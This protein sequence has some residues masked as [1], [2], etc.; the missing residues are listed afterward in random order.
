MS[1]RDEI[2]TLISRLTGQANVLTIPV[3]FIDFAGSLDAAL[4]LSQILYW[5]D[6]T[7][8]REGW[9]YKTYGQWKDELR[10]TEYEVRKAARHLVDL[11]AIEVEVRRAAGSPT[12]HYRISDNFSV[13]IL[14]K[15]QY[16]NQRN[17]R[18]EPSKSKGSLQYRD[19]DKDYAETTAATTLN[20]L[21]EHV[22]A[23]AAKVIGKL[24]DGQ[25]E[26][27]DQE[28]E[29]IGGID[30][31]T[32]DMLDYAR[33]EALSAAER[34]NLKYFMQVLKRCVEH[35]HTYRQPKSAR[36]SPQARQP[37]DPAK[38]TGNGKYA[39]LFRP[40]EQAGSDYEEADIFDEE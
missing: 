7:E 22:H 29:A 11:G 3:L 35:P 14:K 9:F 34:R 21:P 12:V 30:L 32:P 18:M 5:S 13:S 36:S 33:K 2:L 40:Q 10:L 31:L 4:L 16:G 28:V 37:L 20:V 23:A 6:R 17:S 8:D 39:G 38:Y 27:L 19:S 26:Y 1:R 24:N 25:I 15:L